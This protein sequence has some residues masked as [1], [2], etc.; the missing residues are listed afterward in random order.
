M[1]GTEATGNLLL[2]FDHP[3]ISLCL[4]IVKRNRKIVQE[5][6]HSPLPLRESIQQIPSR[7][8][9]GSPWGSL[10]GRRGGGISVVAFGEDLII[11]TKQACQHQHLQFVLATAFAYSNLEFLFNHRTFTF[12]APT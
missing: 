4:V 3:K 5:L 6:E 1:F 12:H 8:L 2:D 11:A 10:L 7:A 9:F